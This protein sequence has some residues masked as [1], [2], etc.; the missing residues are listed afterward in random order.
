M[1]KDFKQKNEN[2]LKTVFA[3]NQEY[4]N[5]KTEISKE[6]LRVQEFKTKNDEAKQMSDQK[7]QDI[8][9]AKNDLSALRDKIQKVKEERTRLNMKVIYLVFF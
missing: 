3:L 1:E 8:A 5:I 4:D 2:S 7:L 6:N 9:K